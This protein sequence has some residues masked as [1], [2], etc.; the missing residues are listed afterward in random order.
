MFYHF[1]SFPKTSD[2]Y[3]LFLSSI[4][5]WHFFLFVR[6]FLESNRC[7]DSHTCRNLTNDHFR[8]HLCGNSPIGGLLCPK[9]SPNGRFFESV[10]T[11]TKPARANNTAPPT[12]QTH[13]IWWL[14]SHSSERSGSNGPRPVWSRFCIGE[15]IDEDENG[16]ESRAI[17]TSG[18]TI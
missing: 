17:Q 13:L 7:P 12:P 10:A 3:L 6:K 15:G 8:L 2:L 9:P 18:S 16:C 11:A 1:E 5:S 14:S 4:G